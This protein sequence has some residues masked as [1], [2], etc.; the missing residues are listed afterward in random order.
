[1]F[2][3]VSIWPFVIQICCT[4]YAQRLGDIAPSLEVYTSI[5]K[6]QVWSHILWIEKYPS[7]VVDFFVSLLND[8]VEKTFVPQAISTSHQHFVAT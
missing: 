3:M 8:W 6:I 5:K 7:R 4:I 1:M 2:P